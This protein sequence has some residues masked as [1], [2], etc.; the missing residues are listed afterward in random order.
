MVKS[1]ELDEHHLQ[2]KGRAVLGDIENLG[3]LAKHR[4]AEAAMNEQEDKETTILSTTEI[5][6][7][8]F[9]VLLTFFIL[10]KLSD[11]G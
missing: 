5:V 7:F 3:Y 11:K 6:A 1:N 4:L 9:G 8:V 2:P 10:L